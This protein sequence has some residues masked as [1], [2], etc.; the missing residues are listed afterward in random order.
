[1]KKKLCLILACVLT[2]GLLAGCGSKTATDGKFELLLGIPDGDELSDGRILENFKEARKD[3]YVVKTDEAT[4]SELTQKI[5]LQLAAKQDV[6]P[7]FITDC[8]NAY[9][10]GE[11]GALKD[12]DASIA[13][14]DESLYTAALRAVTNPEGKVWGVPQAINSYGLI[15]NKEI[16]DERG[17]AYPTEDWT[18]EDYLA[19]AEK[20]TF[21]RE[22]GEKVYGMDA[23]ETAWRV[24]LLANGAEPLKDGGRN[25]NLNDPK[26]KA[27]FEA[28]LRPW[29]SGLI[30]D[31]ADLSAL[32]GFNA[33]FADGRIAMGHVQ[34]ST[35]NIIHG[36]KPE[37]DFDALLSPY[38]WNG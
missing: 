1:M 36:L 7:V 17:V 27:G 2:L 37:L 20:L 13:T 12:L 9:V 14:L 8:G 5:K 19:A 35:A 38:G 10:F 33:A 21:E 16:F 4:W 31:Q 23:H 18:Y 28:F 30:M 26:V 25:S 22:N 24:W 6:I 34:I 3:Q 15:Y 11:Q 32:G 29:D